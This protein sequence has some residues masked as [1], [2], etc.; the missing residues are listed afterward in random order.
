M[1]TPHVFTP[2]SRDLTYEERAT[3]GP[4]PICHAPHGQPCNPEVG[5]ALGR[6]AH[7]EIPA[8]GAHLGRLQRAPDRVRLVP[9]QEAP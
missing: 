5:L 8:G 4:C 1:P 3:W 2:P 9:V 6:N 7:G